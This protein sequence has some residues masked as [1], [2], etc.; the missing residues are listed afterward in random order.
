M[1]SCAQRPAAPFAQGEK[2]TNL[3]DAG[4]EAVLPREVLDD[5]DALQHLV[6]LV[7]PLAAAPASKRRESVTEEAAS[8]G[9]ASEGAAGEEA[10]GEEGTFQ[11]GASEQTTG[12]SDR[13]QG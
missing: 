11:R 12:I 1:D 8:E 10:A 2:T 7:G 4:L 3:G 5:A 9:A 13:R 6:H